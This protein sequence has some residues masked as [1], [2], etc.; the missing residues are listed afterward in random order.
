MNTPV[1]RANV[2]QH[3]QF[4][5]VHVHDSLEGTM[6]SNLGDYQRIV[7][8]AKKVGGPKRLA[9][10]IVGVGYGVGRGVEAGGRYVIRH[11]RANPVPCETKGKVFI[12]TSGGSSAGLDLKPGDQY[13]VL[14]CDDDAILIER[15]GD[16]ESPYL[17]SDALLRAVS[18]YPRSVS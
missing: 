17:V 14:E 11:L 9:V 16:S 6:S 2:P 3:G 10:I 1:K 12:V 15:L 8:W 4:S 13:R 5:R 18:S 7:E